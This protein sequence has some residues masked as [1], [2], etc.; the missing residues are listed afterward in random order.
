M[1]HVPDFPCSLFEHDSLVQSDPFGTTP[2][3]QSTSSS[4][5]IQAPHLQALRGPTHRWLVPCN[6]QD[7]C[8]A[9]GC[10]IGGSDLSRHYYWCTLGGAPWQCRSASDSCLICQQ[11]L[12]T[13]AVCLY[14][15]GK[16]HTINVNVSPKKIH[17]CLSTAHAKMCQQ[18]MPTLLTCVLKHPQKFAWTVILRPFL[19]WIIA[20][21]QILL[22]KC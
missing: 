3:A 7:V 6:A 5:R 18:L 20:V 21:E 17:G 12:S 16:R 11:L 14:Q 10:G 13:D 15:N 9:A 22:Y 19:V 8:I 4:S 2:S 1:Q